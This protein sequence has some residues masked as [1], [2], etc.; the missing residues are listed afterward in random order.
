M[1][2]ALS[3]DS[4]VYLNGQILT[5]RQANFGIEDRG[6]FFADGVYEVTRYYHGQPL[7]LDGHLAR[8]RRSLAEIGLTEP[9][10]LPKLHDITLELLKNNRTPEASVYW[11]ITRGISSPRQHPFPDPTKIKPSVMILPY[12]VKAIRI[13][14][15]I[16][17]LTA[18]CVPDVRWHRCD[19]K[20]L[21]LL[22]NSLGKN[23][24][25]ARGADEAILHR[26]QAITEG[27]ATN[28]YVVRR[29]VIRTHP[30]DGH[31]LPGITRDIVIDLAR[32]LGIPLVEQ[33]AM[34]DE[35]CHANEVFITGTTT[36]VACVVKI[37]GQPVHHGRPGPIAQRLHQAMLAKIMRDCPPP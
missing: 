17:T 13:D 3:D 16:A 10:D 29:G 2:D 15:P 9:A 8:F 37:D 36:Q 27:S 1:A 21:M 7:A 33:P 19:I 4:L 11:Q 14:Q 34:L 23:Q 32:Q 12:P 24:A 31:I 28:V 25:M 18:A 26:G 30:S 6:L 20:T 35:L 22:A 5:K